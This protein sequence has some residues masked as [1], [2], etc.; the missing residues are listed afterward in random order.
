VLHITDSQIKTYPILYDDWPTN[1]VCA[2]TITNEIT[3]A[4]VPVMTNHLASAEVIL[5]GIKTYSNYAAAINLLFT[6]GEICRVRGHQWA[7]GCGM[8]GCLVMHYGETRH[9]TICGTYQSRSMPSWPGE[10]PSQGFL[11][12]SLT[13][14]VITT[15][16]MMGT[17]LLWG[18]N[19]ILF[20]DGATNVGIKP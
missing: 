3:I 14:Y 11:P 8:V 13:N 15:N 10:N 17:N 16:M 6:S 20:N 2:V 5:A 12:F 18:T 9:C 7:P 1:R 4:H 19:I